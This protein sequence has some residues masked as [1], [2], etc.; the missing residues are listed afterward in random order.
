MSPFGVGVPRDRGGGEGANAL[1]RLQ[2]LGTM[3]GASGPR[4]SGP[5]QRFCTSTR[6]RF[7]GV[8]RE[9]CAAVSAFAFARVEPLRTRLR[10]HLFCV[11]RLFS[12][13]PAPIRIFFVGSR[14]RDRGGPCSSTTDRRPGQRNVLLGRSTNAIVDPQRRPVP[15]GQ[16]G[17][18]DRGDPIKWPFS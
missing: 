17:T 12:A 7:P 6:L 3:K 10:G 2:A 16:I 1:S 15:I 8:A 13:C 5:L 18:Y 11:Q 14:S 9:I 4:R